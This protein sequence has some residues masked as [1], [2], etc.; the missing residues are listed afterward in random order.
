ME[1]KLYRFLTAY[2]DW[3]GIF[4]PFI[5]NSSSTAGSCFA[6]VLENHSFLLDCKK[7]I[8]EKVGRYWR[9][10]LSWF[11]GNNH[12]IRFFYWSFLEN[13][14]TLKYWFQNILKDIDYQYLHSIHFRLHPYLLFHR[15]NL[16]HIQT[17][18][19]FHSFI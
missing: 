13:I 10:H 12:M 5:L 9:Y 2:I 1:K 16:C 11:H 15:S 8:H 3:T 4:Y 6:R 18:S 7:N 17:C 19:L 14:Q